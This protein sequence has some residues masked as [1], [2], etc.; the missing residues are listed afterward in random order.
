[1]SDTVFEISLQLFICRA[2]QERINTIKEYTH[3]DS[4]CDIAVD[5][6]QLS[7]VAL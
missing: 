6:F 4:C 1:M 3:F 7:V 5:Y 2:N